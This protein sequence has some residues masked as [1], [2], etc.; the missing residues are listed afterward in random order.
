MTDNHAEAIAAIRRCLELLDNVVW[1]DDRAESEACD[2]RQCAED[3]LDTLAAAYPQAQGLPPLGAIENGREF[4]RRLEEHYD[5]KEGQG[6]TLE[7][8][9]EWVHLK[10]CFEHLAA[11]PI[12]PPAP[13]KETKDE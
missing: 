9:Y 11:I 4:M 6:H 1:D 10:I 3:A 2:K 7:K 13:I 12:L 8:C 5:F